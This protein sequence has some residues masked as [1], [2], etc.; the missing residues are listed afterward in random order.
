MVKNKLVINEHRFSKQPYDYLQKIS[1]GKKKYQNHR[2][3]LFTAALK[4]FIQFLSCP[5]LYIKKKE[6]VL[7]FNSITLSYYFCCVNP[8]M[9]EYWIDWCHHIFINCIPECYYF[10]ISW[11]E[12]AVLFSICDF[13]THICYTIC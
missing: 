10:V 2:G 6:G 7:L 11:T 4:S 5:F 13:T 8:S 9:C 3:R 12:T 1:I